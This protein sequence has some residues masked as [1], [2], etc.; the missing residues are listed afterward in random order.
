MSTDHQTIKQIPANLMFVDTTYQ[1]D[2][3]L[4]H[5]KFASRAKKFDA[6]RLNLLTVSKRSDGRWAILDGAGR[7]Y[8]VTQILNKHSFVFNCTAYEGLSYQQEVQKN[9]SLNQ[10]RDNHKTIDMFRIDVAQKEPEAV[11][12]MSIVT[13]EGLEEK[14]ILSPEVFT[15]LHR[16]D[17][18]KSTLHLVKTMWGATPRRE[19]TSRHY[20]GVGILMTDPNLNLP[21]LKEVMKNTS[22]A[23]IQT[24]LRSG[25]NGVQHP[26]VSSVRVAIVLARK[27]NLHLS[28]GKRI[29][30]LEQFDN[31]SIG[32]VFVYLKEKR[33]QTT[34]SADVIKMTPK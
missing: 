10:D 3:A 13:S 20:G 22:P 14:D 12:I 2:P 7:H 29:E 23:A 17:V 33:N 30:T 9:K 21:R 4:R 8:M 16:Q 25:F 5:A 32:K 18:L 27:Y 24:A 28:M 31:E 34:S 6:M 1:R 11:A 15:I 19:L 26:K